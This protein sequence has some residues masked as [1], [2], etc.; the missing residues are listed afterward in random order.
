MAMQPHPAAG[1]P[2]AV[3]E[4][5]AEKAPTGVHVVSDETGSDSD[6]AS[7]PQAGVQ[8]VEAI[9]QVWDRNMLWITFIL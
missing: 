8:Q 9:T 5:G 4:S 6:S 1:V 7:V 3:D 2:M